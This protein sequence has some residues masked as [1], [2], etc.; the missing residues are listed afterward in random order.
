MLY[1]M[2]EVTITGSR[3]VGDGF[4]LSFCLERE[5]KKNCVCDN[6]IFFIAELKDVWS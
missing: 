4:F 2:H 1:Y 5:G 3:F 6:F